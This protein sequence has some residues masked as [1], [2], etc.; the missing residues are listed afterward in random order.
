MFGK[1]KVYK[2]TYQFVTPSST[3]V[4]AKN[5]ISALKKFRKQYYVVLDIISI[6]EISD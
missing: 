5:K 6:E 3:L 1:K 2:I 4:V